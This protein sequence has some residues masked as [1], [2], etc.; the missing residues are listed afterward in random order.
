MGMKL[1]VFSSV[2]RNRLA[3]LG[4]ANIP[5]SAASYIESLMLQELA[6]IAAR[7]I[8]VRSVARAILRSHSKTVSKAKTT[9]DSTQIVSEN[10]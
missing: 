8:T 3:E 9:S 5:T 6:V 1:N 7:K 10:A 4:L 2:V